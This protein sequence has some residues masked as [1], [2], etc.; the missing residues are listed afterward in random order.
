MTFQNRF[1]IVLN[2]NSLRIVLNDKNEDIAGIAD[3]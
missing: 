2:R 1:T 3:M